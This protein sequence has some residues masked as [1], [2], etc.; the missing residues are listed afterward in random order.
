MHDVSR[1]LTALSAT[2]ALSGLVA[3]RIENKALA[4]A[5]LPSRIKLLNWG[6]NKTIKGDVLVNERTVEALAANQ[7]AEGFDKI[8][9]DFNHNS[10]PG[11]PNYKADP[12]EVAAYGVPEIIPGDGLYLRDVEWT[13]AGRQYAKNYCDLSPTPRLENGVVVFLHSV[14]LCPQGAVEGLSFF[15]A[16]EKSN[17]NPKD[18]S[19][20]YKKLLLLLLGLDEKATDEAISQAATAWKDKLSAMSAVFDSLKGVDL[21]A[22]SALGEKIKGVDLTALSA[23]VQGVT[24]EQFTALS[25]RVD[26]LV[27]NG[28]K[29]AREAILARAASEGKVIPLNADQINGIPL[30][31]LET[32]VEKLPVTVP[33]EKRTPANVTPLSVSNETGADAEVMKTLGIAKEAW[34]KHNG[35]TGTVIS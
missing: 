17:P 25:A 28:D 21:K 19:M 26:G 5:D 32:M 6:V 20:D 29:S 22:L 16:P 12:R 35:A 7:A 15:S 8:A 30:S 23:A 1:S 9:L 14:A 2:A 4:S 24:V 18:T 34:T 33:L 11:H 31:A 13:P 27:K 10:L 3:F